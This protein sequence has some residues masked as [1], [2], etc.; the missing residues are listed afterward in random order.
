MPKHNITV[1]EVKVTF[2]AVGTVQSASVTGVCFV[3]DFTINW[4]NRETVIRKCSSSEFGIHYDTKNSMTWDPITFQLD[5]FKHDKADDIQKFL[6]DSLEYTTGTDFDMADPLGSKE[7]KIKLEWSDPNS[8]VFELQGFTT[9][10]KSTA[11][12]DDEVDL[13][14]TFQPTTKPLRT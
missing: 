9:S 8:N 5:G 14:F 10:A 13:Q 1:P 3:E 2:T 11:V 6:F 4:G 12:I 7:W